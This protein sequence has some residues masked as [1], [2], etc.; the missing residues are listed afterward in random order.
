[1]K[2]PETIGYILNVFERNVEP[3]RGLGPESW[4]KRAAGID[5]MIA[6]FDAGEAWLLREGGWPFIALRSRT[7][8]PKVAPSS[9]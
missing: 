6:G 3:D 1:M 4:A 7:G 8:Y 9:I 5:S 2:K